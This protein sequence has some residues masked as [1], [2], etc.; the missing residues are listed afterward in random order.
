MPC[1]SLW[2]LWKREKHLWE[3]FISPLA[4]AKFSDVVNHHFLTF[5]QESFITFLLCH[6]SDS[7]HILIIHPFLW[8][9]AK[10]QFH[11]LECLLKVIH[12]SALFFHELRKHCLLIM[13][14]DCPAHIQKVMFYIR[15]QRIVAHFYRTNKKLVLCLLFSGYPAHK[16]SSFKTDVLICGPTRIQLP[17]ELP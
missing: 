2:R 8:G 13:Q 3:R 6:R 17:H 4:T 7:F 5:L 1:A 11:C 12:I 9:A 16:L 10:L 14:T 15:V